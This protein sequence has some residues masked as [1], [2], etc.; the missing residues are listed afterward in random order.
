MPAL[1]KGKIT[2]IVL[3]GGQSKR[4]GRDKALLEVNGHTLIDHMIELLHSLAL[5]D[6]YVSG[7]YEGYK[8]LPDQHPGK[9]P[10]AAMVDILKTLPPETKGILVVPVD[11][12]FL[13][14]EILEELMNYPQGAFYADRHF[15]AFLPNIDITATFTDEPV[16]ALFEHIGL[17]MLDAPRDQE[18]LFTNVNTP[19][20]WARAHVHL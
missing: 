3:A 20:E 12:P 13:T 1:D 16:M 2:G 19:E 5:K 4:M 18:T 15:P 8:C 10:A 9:G 14:T 17:K 6:I 11:M 7:N